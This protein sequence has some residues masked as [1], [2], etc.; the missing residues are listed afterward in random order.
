MLDWLGLIA[1]ILQVVSSLFAFVGGAFLFIRHRQLKN[2]LKALS[3]ISSERPAA[4]AVSLGASNEQAVRAHL[5]D[6]NQEISLLSITH[7][8]I[9]QPTDFP[10]LLANLKQIKQRFT[11]TSITELHL[12][13]LG[14]VTFA[15]AVG[16]MLNNWV[17][18]KVY[19]FKN[20]R[21]ELDFVLNREMILTPNRP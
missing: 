4:L 12:F 7:E 13:Y 2:R 1:N 20:G 17:P 6:T 11:D 14:P 16:A 19:S 5:R 21:Y 10:R 8:G 3:E 9:A 18:V 15:A